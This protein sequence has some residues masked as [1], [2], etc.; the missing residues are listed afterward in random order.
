MVAA[1]NFPNTS[2]TPAWSQLFTQPAQPFPLTSLQVLKGKVP[3]ELR[4]ALFRNGPGRLTRGN[5]AMGHWFDGDGAILGVY[6]TETGV[7][8]QYRYVETPY[9]QEETAA[10]KLLHPNY[11]TLAPGKIWQRWGKPAKNS[12]NTSVLPLGDRLLALWEAGKPYG[13]DCQTLE[14]LGEVDLGFAHRSDTFSAHHKIQPETGE[15]YN[16]GVTFGPQ[17]TFQLYRCNPRGKISQQ[18]QFSV[19]DLKGLP[20]V[21]D[22][23]LAGDYLIF[24][25]PPVRLQMVPAL[26]GLKTVSDALQWRPEL[27]TT[28]VIV[29]RHTLKPIS[30]SQQDAWFQW[31]FTNGYVNDQGEIVLEM[32]RFPDFASNLQ[33]V[34]IPQGKIQTY[35]KGTLWRYRLEPETAKVIEAYEICDRSCEFPITL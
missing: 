18:R 30:F 17:A 26:L 14:T 9:L 27:G 22:F 5:E 4:G 23:V 25:I 21:H 20:L 12:A 29:D 28:V 32:V 2:L 19:P 6:F 13:L 34:E 10:G 7:Q 15:I 8:A 11:G 31:H 1:S 33:F 35:T 24:C 16:F 3:S